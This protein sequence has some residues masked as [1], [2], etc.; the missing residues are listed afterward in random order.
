MGIEVQEF[1]HQR[2]RIAGFE[3]FVLV[4]DLILP[5]GLDAAGQVDLMTFAQIEQSARGNRQHQFV[6]D[7]LRHAFPPQVNPFTG[8][9]D[10]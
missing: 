4:F 8:Y 5:I 3:D 9:V 2:E 7:V 1:L 6:V 10:R